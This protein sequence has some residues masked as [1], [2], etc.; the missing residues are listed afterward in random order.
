MELY[1]LTDELLVAGQIGPDTIPFLAGQG[2]RAIICNRFDGEEPG[3]PSF[4]PV[5]KAAA[6]H[7]ITAVSQPVLMPP[8]DITDEEAAVFGKLLDELPK[9]V[10]AYC[11]TGSRCAILWALSEARRRP[12]KEVVLAAMG[13]GYDLTKYAPR[14][15]SL[16]RP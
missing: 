8:A 1:E 5:G 12:F 4:Q 11:R 2:I 7:G 16:Y 13:A 3:Q 9:P 14:F 10:L 6:T 15:Q